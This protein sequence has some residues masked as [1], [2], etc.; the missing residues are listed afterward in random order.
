MENIEWTVGLFVLV[1]EKSFQKNGLTAFK[2]IYNAL[3]SK[4]SGDIMQNE[5]IWYHIWWTWNTLSKWVSD[6]LS[7]WIQTDRQE[8]TLWLRNLLLNQFWVQL[9]LLLNLDYIFP[10][11]FLFSELFIN[12]RYF[13][14]VQVLL[15]N[16]KVTL[17][18]WVPW[19]KAPQ[20]T[21]K[22]SALGR[23]SGCRNQAYAETLEQDVILQ[24]IGF[25][26]NIQP[27]PA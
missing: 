4:N 23:A 7:E 27:I 1:L 15:T 22:W 21:L 25:C 24:F 18:M 9:P 5:Y 6:W 19:R 17:L 26:Q 8:H 2:T 10:H 3:N 14:R 16:Y 20:Y 11:I 13:F 12:S